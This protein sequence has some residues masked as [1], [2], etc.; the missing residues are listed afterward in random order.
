MLAYVCELSAEAEGEVA[1]MFHKCSALTV[2]NCTGLAHDFKSSIQTCI[3][4]ISWGCIP[5]PQQ[6]PGPEELVP[7]LPS[8][9]S[10]QLIIQSYNQRLR[11]LNLLCRKQLYVMLTK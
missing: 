9:L 11:N 8:Y 7:Q 10:Q 2:A 1:R 4:S 5:I 3:L 6:Q